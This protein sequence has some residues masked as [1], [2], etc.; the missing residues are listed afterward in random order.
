MIQH[1]HPWHM[2]VSP[3]PQDHGMPQL[4]PVTVVHWVH[5]W[6]SCCLG[7][8]MCTCAPDS[9]EL[10]APSP[11]V[12]VLKGNEQTEKPPTVFTSSWQPTGFDGFHRFRFGGCLRCAQAW[13]RF[14]SCSFPLVSTCCYARFFS[15]PVWW[16][17]Y[18]H[19]PTI[20]IK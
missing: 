5:A 3:C 13:S 7:P 17:V 12:E 18:F 4:V 16:R 19:F 6:N 14:G 9:D 15:R 20:Q 11:C 1:I 8:D 10:T 2:H